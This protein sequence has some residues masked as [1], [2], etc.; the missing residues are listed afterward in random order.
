MN[1]V[2]AKKTDEAVY[3]YTKFAYDFTLKINSNI[4][5]QR[6]FN[7]NNFNDKSLGSIQLKFAIDEIVNIIDED[8]KSKSRV[9]LYSTCS[10][11]AREEDLRKQQE[12][13]KYKYEVWLEME[14]EF[15]GKSDDKTENILSFKFS[16]NKNPI[17]EKIW[18][19]DYYP[20][21]IRKNIDLT[22]NTQFKGNSDDKT[23]KYEYT[24]LKYINNGREELVPIIISILRDACSLS[25]SEYKTISNY[26]KN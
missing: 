2:E 26:F 1:P 17:I 3:D 22:S 9:Y 14:D 11:F 18:S 24:I 4:I 25:N 5:C 12:V 20:S 10:T 15:K 23:S 13:G 21:F 7:I 19:A 16:V 8:L 6:Y